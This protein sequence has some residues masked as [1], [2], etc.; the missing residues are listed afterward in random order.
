MGQNGR[1]LTQIAPQ[2]EVLAMISM[3]SHLLEPESLLFVVEDGM[4][5]LEHISN[6]TYVPSW[7]DFGHFGP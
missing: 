4:D 3:N 1:L 6:D 7:S 5:G 2:T